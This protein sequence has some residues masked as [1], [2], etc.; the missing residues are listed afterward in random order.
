MNGDWEMTKAYVPALLD[1]LLEV[2]HW[3][4]KVHV[5]IAPPFTFLEALGRYVSGYAIQVGAQNVSDQPK[6][7]YTGEVSAGMLKETG[8]KFCLVGHSER[9]QYFH[10]EEALLNRK[11]KALL[12]VGITPVYCVGETL[13]QRKANRHEAVVSQQLEGGLAGISAGDLS[14]IIIAYEPVW[15]IGTGVNATP[16][17]ANSMHAMV[18]G[19]LAAFMPADQAAQVPILYGGSVNP[20]NAAALLSL[21]EINGALV[22]GASLKPET[23]IPIIASAISATA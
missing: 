11:I 3:E 1:G 6:G 14:R 19:R 4:L 13:E 7:A 18:R 8:Q 16:E 23:F 17:Q 12:S 15:A 20:D 22:G 5:G 9:R 21:P 2:H 10:E